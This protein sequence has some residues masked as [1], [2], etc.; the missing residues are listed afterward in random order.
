M[1]WLIPESQDADVIVLGTPIY[2]GN[3]IHYLQR[4]TERL[5]PTQL[6]WMEEQGEITQHP[7][8]HK[9]KP[10]KMGVQVPSWFII[11]KRETIRDSTTS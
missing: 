4:M 9:K 5:L 8:R 7:S 11:I 3:I 1:D 6:P 2:N 10:Q